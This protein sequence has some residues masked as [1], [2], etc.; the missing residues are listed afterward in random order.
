MNDD[1]DLELIEL[2][3]IQSG[4]DEQESSISASGS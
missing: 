1:L 4:D 2:E 3:E